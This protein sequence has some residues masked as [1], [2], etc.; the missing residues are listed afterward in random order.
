MTLD[1]SKSITAHHNIVGDIFD[2][3][4]VIKLIFTKLIYKKNLIHNEKEKKR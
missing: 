1:N 3:V 4:V 2:L